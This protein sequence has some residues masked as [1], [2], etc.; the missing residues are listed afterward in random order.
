MQSARRT[1]TQQTTKVNATLDTA[2]F[3][4]TVDAGGVIEGGRTDAGGLLEQREQNGGAIPLF[5]TPAGL[6]KS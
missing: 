6:V 4:N 3:T 5:Q 1:T 2:I